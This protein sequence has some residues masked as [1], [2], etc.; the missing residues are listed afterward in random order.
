MDNAR[1]QLSK[2]EEKQANAAGINMARYR[3]NN[4]RGEFGEAPLWAV[5]QHIVEGRLQNAIDRMNA[6]IST[7]LI[8]KDYFDVVAKRVAKLHLRRAL[9]LMRES[10]EWLSD[11]PE[12]KDL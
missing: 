6:D 12:V 10:N 5:P 3:I 8:F 4:L 9:I 2:E 1:E 11:Y 7:D